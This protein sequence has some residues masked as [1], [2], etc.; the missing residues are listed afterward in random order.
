MSVFCFSVVACDVP[1]LTVKL[2]ILA[3]DGSSGL[4][5]LVQR[6]ADGATLNSP[7]ANLLDKLVEGLTVEVEP[8]LKDG[9]VNTLHGLADNNSL[10]HA[11]QLFEA[12]DIGDQVGVEVIAVQRGPELVVRGADQLAVEGVE[13][14]DC[15]G[16]GVGGG[17]GGEDVRREEGEAEAEVGGGEDG[18]RLDEDVGDGLFTAEVGVELVAVLLV[19]QSSA[20]AAS[21][22]CRNRKECG[23]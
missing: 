21:V 11:H 9:T 3:H 6:N 5:L 22:Q 10:A 18:Q 2:D 12:L 4:I 7:S 15:F 13:L 14:L 23:V 8:R 19:C 20:V 16:E 1:K 17:V